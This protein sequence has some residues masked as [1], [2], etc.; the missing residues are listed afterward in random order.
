MP[1]RLGITNKKSKTDHEKEKK[2]WLIKILKKRKE[3][4]K[5]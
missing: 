5:I 1:L 2:N 4:L 3:K